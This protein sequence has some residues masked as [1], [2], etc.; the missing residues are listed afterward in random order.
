MV[1]VAQAE[2]SIIYD[3]DD[4]HKT[5]AVQLENILLIA[6]LCHI[7]QTDRMLLL[8]DIFTTSTNDVVQSLI[9]G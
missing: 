3:D 1:T 8:Y 5:D 6:V 7:S 4:E 2:Q 9:A